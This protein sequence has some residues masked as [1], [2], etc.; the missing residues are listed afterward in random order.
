LRSLESVLKTLPEPL[1]V[2]NSNREVSPLEELLKFA[3]N[4]TNR[5]ISLETVLK[6]EEEVTDN[7]SNKVVTEED[8]VEDTEDSNNKEVSVEVTEENLRTVIPVGVLVT[9][10]RTVRLHPSVSTVEELVN[11]L[12]SLACF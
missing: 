9:E 6:M 4:V 11:T 1:K 2:S 12:F 3:T 8:T 5:V 7:N 10:L